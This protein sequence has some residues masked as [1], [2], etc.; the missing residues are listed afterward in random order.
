MNHRS[1]AAAAAGI[2]FRGKPH[3]EVNVVFVVVPQWT[4]LAA[5]RME[6]IPAVARVF[7]ALQNTKTSHWHAAL[8][9]RGHAVA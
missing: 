7:S 3:N 5:V 2:R 9:Q 8:Q 1:V 4:A 6:T